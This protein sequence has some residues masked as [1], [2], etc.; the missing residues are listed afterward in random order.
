MSFRAKQP[1]WTSTTRTISRGCRKSALV[2]GPA[3]DPRLSRPAVRGAAFAAHPAGIAVGVVFLLPDRQPDLHL[4]DDVAAGVEGGIPVRRRHA[5]PHRAL[6]DLE[7]PV[8]V[9]AG[10][11]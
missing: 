8:P 2:E 10:G 9:H 1:R 3:T 6:A 7:Q 4:V 5:D 11:V